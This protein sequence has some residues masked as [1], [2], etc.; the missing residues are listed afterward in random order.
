MKIVLAT[1]NKDKVKEIK[2]FLK[3][4]EIYALSEI[5][6]PFDIV[7]DGSSFKEN[8]L[9]KV[10][11][12]YKRLCELGLEGEFIALS[13]DSGISVDAL[14]G[15]PGIYSARFSGDGATDKLNRQK[16]KKE[17]NDL[18]LKSSKAHYSACIAIASKFGDYTAHGF[19]YGAAIDEERGENGFGYDFMFIPNGFDKTIG[20][21]SDNVKLKIS[22]RSK[23]LA[24]SEIIL[25]KLAKNF[26]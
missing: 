7:E 2:D 11:A 12:V 24:L 17:L 10:R 13:D 25:K 9:I 5:M 6:T 26:R 18:G 19:M 23:G 4:Y 1:S 3:D 8:A 15:R 14:D 21:L 22:H 16:L 20:E